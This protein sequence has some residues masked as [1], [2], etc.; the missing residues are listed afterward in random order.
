MDIKELIL[1]FYKRRGYFW[2]TVVNDSEQIHW[3]VSMD[4][5]PS[6]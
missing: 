4:L 1:H 3:H 5:H 2:E 6:F